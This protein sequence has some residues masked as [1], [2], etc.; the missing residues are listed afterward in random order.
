MFAVIFEVKP[1]TAGKDKYLEIAANLRTFLGGREGF[2]SIER[3]R[4]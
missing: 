1:T 2:L 4:A 3:F